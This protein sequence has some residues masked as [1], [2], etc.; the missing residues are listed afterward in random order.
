MASVLGVRVNIEPLKEAGLLRKRR[1]ECSGGTIGQREIGYT[2]KRPGHV[3]LA[4]RNRRVYHGVTY[5]N[6]PLRAF[7]SII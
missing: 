1:S 5:P 6:S 3:G 7:S 4:E 2:P